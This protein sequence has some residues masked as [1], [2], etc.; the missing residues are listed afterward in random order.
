MPEQVIWGIHPGRHGGAEDLFLRRNVIA[1]G[2]G[3][4]GDLSQW[5]DREGYK[6][7]FADT[8]PNEKPGAVPTKAGMLYRFVHEMQLGDLV[9]CPLKLVREVSIGEVVGEY[10][11]RPD[12]NDRFPNMREVKWVKT[13]PRTS[14]SQGA[15]YEMGSAMTLF[16][17]SSHADEVLAILEGRPLEPADEEGEIAE[18]T[19]DVEDQT[20]DYVLKQL[21]RKLKGHAFAAFVGHL[22]EKMGYRTRVSAP[23]PDHGID[24][25]AHRDELGF[26]PPLVKVQVKSSEGSIGEPTVSSLYGK[27]D[28]KEF[29]LLVTLGRFS[30]QAKN[31]AFSKGNLRLIDGDEL[32]DLIFDYY[33]QL[34]PRYKGMI[35]LKRIYVPEALSEE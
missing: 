33:E 29:G 14:F 15:L 5:S 3:D 21:A 9:V 27:V 19:S 12:V 25:I 16:Q 34:D 8:Y 11:H 10:Q 7:A 20:R 13:V 23:G 31:F 26:E 22:L 35:P 6:V 4:M 1:I 32:V 2:W 17:I 30:S 18:I 24:I 28:E